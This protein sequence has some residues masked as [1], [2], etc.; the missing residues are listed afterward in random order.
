M[1]SKNQCLISGGSLPPFA[2]SFAI[3]CLCSQMFMLAES[4]VSPVY[5]SSFA[6]SL[7]AVRLESIS[8][9][10]IRS[11][12]EVRHSSFSFLAV[13]ALSRIGATS[14]D[15][16]GAA[17]ADDDPVLAAAPPPAGAAP[18]LDPKIALTVSDRQARDGARTLEA[19][20]GGSYLCAHGR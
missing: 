2:A 6:S 10:F 8:S 17:G 1:K 18:A 9:A 16:P 15:C 11:T 3:T 5:P 13:T 20:R 7:R 14:T 12:I 4:L 19:G